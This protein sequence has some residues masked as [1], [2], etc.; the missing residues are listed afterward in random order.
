AEWDRAR[1]SWAALSS[2][3]G[4]VYDRQI[5][6]DLNAL[7]PMVT[8]GTNPGQA[9]QLRE[10]VPAENAPS[11]LRALEYTAVRPGQSMEGTAVDWA[12][13]GSCT[14]GRIEDL[15]VAAGVLQGSR[16]HERVTLYV[17][18]G[19][20]AVRAQAVSEGLD[21]IFVAAGAQFRMPGCSLCLAMNDDK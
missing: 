16:V 15:R 1:A 11:V 4:A 14:N 21:K 3:E 19:S 20:E 12:F 18:P 2:D 17:V 7:G 13:I 6:I 8:W 5:V 9:V 10:P